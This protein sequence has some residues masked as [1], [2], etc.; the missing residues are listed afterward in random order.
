V[1]HCSTRR[2][3]EAEWAGDGKNL[4]G[5]VKAL[6]GLPTITVGSVGLDTDVMTVFMEGVD[7]GA[8]VAEAIEDLEE[9]LLADEFDLVAVGRA[10]IG[11]PDF[12]RKVEQ[13]D[14]AAIRTFARADLGK[15][16]WDTSIVEEAHA[17]LAG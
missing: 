5:W 8:R 15:L 2:F 16:E 6:S 11:D 12:V 13:R 10:L 7:P 4:A 3:W 1:L 14:Y 9:R 17:G